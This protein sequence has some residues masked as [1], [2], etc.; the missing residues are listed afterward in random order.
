[1]VETQISGPEG[2]FFYS[3]LNFSTTARQISVKSGS[4]CSAF[5]RAFFEPVSADLVRFVVEIL[6][7]NAILRT[8][9]WK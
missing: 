7:V 3:F 1:M 2:V 8:A 6:G 9:A 5:Q 4:F